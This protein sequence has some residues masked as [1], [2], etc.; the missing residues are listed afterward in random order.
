MRRFA[1]ILAAVLLTGFQTTTQTPLRVLP[2]PLAALT[3]DATAAR[4]FDYMAL[5][6]EGAD[7]RGLSDTVYM[8][9]A[10]AD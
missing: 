3:E 1:T 5:K 2:A 8:R 9:T 4:A 6:A 10:S 7:L